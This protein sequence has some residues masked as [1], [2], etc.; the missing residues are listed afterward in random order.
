MLS[1]WCTTFFRINK[2]DKN[3]EPWVCAERRNVWDEN[4]FSSAFPSVI[5]FTFKL[6]AHLLKWDIRSGTRVCSLTGWDGSKSF[7]AAM[8]VKSQGKRLFGKYL[9]N[10]YMSSDDRICFLDFPLL[11][12]RVLPTFRRGRR[13]ATQTKT[14]IVM[15]KHYAP[16]IPCACDFRSDFKRSLRQSTRKKWTRSRKNLLNN[17]LE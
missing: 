16:Q 6:T 9:M 14:T 15:I 1:L 13:R 10:L 11:G 8:R 17:A 12:V 4:C 5:N 2:K 3:P 7:L